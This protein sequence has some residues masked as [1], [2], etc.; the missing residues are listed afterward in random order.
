MKKGKSITL[1]SIISVLIAFVLFMTFVPFQMGIKD[2]NA[3]IGAVDLDYDLEGGVAYTLTLAEDNE[4]EVEDVNEVIDVLE[5]RLSALGYGV[6]SVKALK[7]TDAGVKDYSI[8]IETE[9]RDTLTE[10]IKVVAAHGELKFFGG[11]SEDSINT[12]ILTDMKVIK[13]AKYTGQATTGQFEM[14]IEFTKEAYDELIKLIES[15][16][17]YFLKV[18]LGAGEMHDD[19]AHENILFQDKIDATYFNRRVMPLYSTSETS[20]RQMA[21]QMQSGGLAYEYELD[22]GVL[23]S[24]PYGEDAGL[25]CAVAIIV[26]AVV[27]MAL[28]ILAYKGFGIV[29]ALSTL[30][31]I[32]G[33]SWLLIGIPG[34]VLNIGG[35]IGIILATVLCAFGMI[36]LANRVRDE[37]ATG[38]KTVKA[39]INQ[40]FA[41]SLVPTISVNV[42]AGLIALMLF[43][44]AKGVIKGFA[45]TF[46]IGAVVSIIATLV[47]T[48]MFNSLIMP[49]VKDKEK[50]LGVT[51]NDVEEEA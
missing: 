19:H 21:L 29:T 45:I 37:I 34:I 44:F 12:E 43:A 39:A 40:S 38:K 31:F 28:L 35:V 46:G 47:F 32:L 26:T 33:E 25:K 50:F 13:S 7:S 27:I 1:L 9:A 41:K 17:A 48:R 49:L 8:R 10:D 15:E 11:T 4:N 42:I 23:I 5:Y 30:L 16:P 51:K 20:A 22:D 3:L 24:A 2:Y 6:Y 36:I 14:K 18:T